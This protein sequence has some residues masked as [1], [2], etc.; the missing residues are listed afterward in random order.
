[1]AKYSKLVAFGRKIS[2]I[3]ALSARRPKI[4]ASV[5]SLPAG[6]RRRRREPPQDASSAGGGPPFRPVSR[7]LPSAENS[8][9]IFFFGRKSGR[10][11]RSGNVW[12]V[13]R[14]PRWTITM[15]S[16][17]FS[18]EK[19]AAR[20][21]V[22]PASPL[23]MSANVG[24]RRVCAADRAAFPGGGRIVER[25]RRRDGFEGAGGP[26]GVRTRAFPAV[27]AHRKGG[28]G[29]V[30]RVADDADGSFTNGSNRESPATGPASGRG[31]GWGDARLLLE[32]DVEMRG[33]FES[34]LEAISWQ[35]SAELV[36]SSLLLL[37]FSSSR[38]CAGRTRRTAGRAGGTASSSCRWRGDLLA[39]E[40]VVEVVLHDDLRLV[41]LCGD[42]H[43][44]ECGLHV[45]GVRRIPAAG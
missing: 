23:R 15:G 13:R 24:N 9:R 17:L 20:N 40:I 28:A 21:S 26:A 44:F 34:A 35:V 39:G 19:A 12:G 6:A 45:L 11:S 42:L 4:G 7:P 37:I 3:G 5:P 1:M 33:V 43:V 8:V 31:T 10:G 41:E 36:S 22:S 27:P 16:G 32:G 25:R 38:Y 18:I 2:R 30:R 14:P 29:T